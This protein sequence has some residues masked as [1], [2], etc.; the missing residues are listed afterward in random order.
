MVAF[1]HNI[2]RAHRWEGSERAGA[3]VSDLQQQLKGNEAQRT[4]ITGY[5]NQLSIQL[6]RWQLRFKTLH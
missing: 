1:K 3:G 5:S 2:A 6:H 4:E